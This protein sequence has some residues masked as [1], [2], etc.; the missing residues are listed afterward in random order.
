M[1]MAILQY[2]YNHNDKQFYSDKLLK[3]GGSFLL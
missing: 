3:K 2:D 1:T